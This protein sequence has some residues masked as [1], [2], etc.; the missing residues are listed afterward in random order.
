MLAPNLPFLTQQKSKF[1]LFNPPVCYLWPATVWW[2][3]TKTYCVDK[4]YRVIY[5]YEICSDLT[6]LVVEWSKIAPKWNLESISRTCYILVLC[7]KRLV[8]CA[9]TKFAFSNP[10]KVKI[11]PFQPSWLLPVTSHCLMA[12]EKTFCVDKKIQS[13]LPLGNSLIF[14]YLRGRMIHSSTK[15]KNRIYSKDLSYLGT[16]P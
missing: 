12:L 2:P 14:D 11:H 1:T 13:D 10:T 3:L 5:H 4:W 16:M 15:M 6:I 9:G 8:H 7:L